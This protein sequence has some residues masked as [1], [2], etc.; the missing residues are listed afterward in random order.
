VIATTPPA[1]ALP[2]RGLGPRARAAVL[3][4]LLAGAAALLRW[5]GYLGQVLPD[6]HAS[7]HWRAAW[8]G[9]DVALTGCLAGTAWSAW[10]R[11]RATAP[12]AAA[13]AA[14]L[15]CDAWFDVLLAADAERWS[16]LVLAAVELPVAGALALLAR[17]LVVGGVPVVRVDPVA[18]HLVHAD[19]DCRRVGQALRRE[20]PALPQ[21]VAAAA[22]LPPTLVAEALERLRAAGV[23]RRRWDG[24]WA[25]RPHDLRWP[26]PDDVRWRRPGD[27]E[28]Y[29]SLL[30]ARFERE[31]TV[32]GHAL[33]RPDRSGPWGS[34]SRAG[35]HL[36]AA[37]LA[38]FHEEYLDLVVRYSRR[39]SRPAAGTRLV[40]LR[41]LAFPHDVVDEIDEGERTP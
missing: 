7:A 5:A 25:V 24:R 39:R 17:P 12:L 6:E 37:E 28:R 13:G 10:R 23:A 32:L 9:L 40:A 29:E 35:A 21:V 2:R 31:L 4:A 3:V 36:T 14:L 15:V 41:F 38:A 22:D 34:G 16:S 11:S 27:R 1:P 33:R 30:T 8:V 26:D 19:D 18:A 20:G